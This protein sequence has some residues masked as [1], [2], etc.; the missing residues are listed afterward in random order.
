MAQQA[1]LV[2]GWDGGTAGAREVTGWHLA[3]FG[4][5]GAMFSTADEL[6]ARDAALLGERVFS[7]AATQRFFSADPALGFVG[8]GQFVYQL[9]GERASPPRLVDREGS[10]GAYRVDNVLL[11]ASGYS[12]I[13]LSHVAGSALGE[14]SCGEGL[15]YD[16]LAAPPEP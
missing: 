11:P 9:P 10:I 14:P 6:F 1:A 4:A 12:L 15:V 5:A 3:N 13:V 16:L 7:P 2:R 8:P